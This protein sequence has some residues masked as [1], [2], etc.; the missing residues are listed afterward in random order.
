[1][2]PVLAK[3]IEHVVP[4]GGAICILRANYQILWVGVFFFFVQGCAS[5][6]QG[7]T[8][9]IAVGSTPSGANV[10]VDGFQRL[11]T[12]A[13]VELSRKESQRLEITLEDYHADI[14]D[15]RQV[16]SNIVAGNIIAEGLIGYAVDHSTGAAFRLVP[17]VVQVNLRP[18]KEEMPRPSDALKKEEP[19]A[20]NTA[21]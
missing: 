12:P 10:I 13:T 5:I 8:Q 2:V 19:E 3:L 7:S 17:E 6:M 15:I 21:N 1:M 16:S 18:I 20:I 9:M 4:K 11:K 14:V